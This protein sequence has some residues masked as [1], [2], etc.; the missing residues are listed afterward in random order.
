LVKEK[1]MK[2]KPREPFIPVERRE[3]I[4]QNIVSILEGKAI[5]A[6]DISADVKV[7]EK[8]VYE[9]LEHI[10]RT[11]NKR[12][13]TLIITP[14]ECKKCGFVFRKR[15]RLTKPGKCPV[16]KS[17]LIQDPLFSVRKAD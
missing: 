11:M 7:S 5:S 16:C 6:K 14:A 4:R 3:T 10:Q 8:E 1:N 13:R 2:K 9:H 15:D 17:Q 12:E